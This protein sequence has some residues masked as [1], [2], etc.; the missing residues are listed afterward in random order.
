M[1][2]GH[3]MFDR[4]GNVVRVSRNDVLELYNKYPE[5][6]D[7]IHVIHFGARKHGDENW[8]KENGK[9]SSHTEMHDSMMHHIAKSYSAGPGRESLCRAEKIYVNRGDSESD[10]DHLLHLMTRAAMCYTLI[11]RRIIHDK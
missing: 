11:Q 1:D 3:N 9:K 8:L 6:F 10:L 2:M 4:L 7:W 5:M